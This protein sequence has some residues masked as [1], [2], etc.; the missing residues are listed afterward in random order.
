VVRNV[1][2]LA[3]AGP[4]LTRQPVTAPRELTGAGRRCRR[5][6]DDGGDGLGSGARL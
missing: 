1:R 6:R 2:V 3:R 4:V 5:A